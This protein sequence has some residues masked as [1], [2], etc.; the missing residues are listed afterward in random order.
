MAATID[1]QSDSRLL[2]A[3]IHTEFEGILTLRTLSVDGDLATLRAILDMSSLSVNGRPVTKPPTIRSRMHMGND[4]TVDRGGYLWLPDTSPPIML[5]VTGL[6]PH[7]PDG[8]VVPGDS[9]TDSISIRATKDRYQGTAHTT[10]VRYEDLDG[11]ATAVIE[12]TRELRFRGGPPL[13]GKGTMS[14]DQTAWVN[15][16]SGRALRMTATVRFSF[17]AR[18]EFIEGV[19]RYELR[20]V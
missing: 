2:D 1:W 19:D 6:T 12:G 16:E 11:V 10:F 5:N 9:W 20:A 18:G 4:G 15:P 17:W 14:I 3:E 8:S 13:P 7:L